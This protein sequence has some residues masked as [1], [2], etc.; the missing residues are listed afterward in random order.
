[1]RHSVSLLLL[2]AAL[3]LATGSLNAAVNKTS[4]VVE[5]RAKER[6]AAKAA[7][8]QEAAAEKKA[9]AAQPP[10]EKKPKPTATI[11]VTFSLGRP[12]YVT[13]VIE[14]AEGER[15]WNLIGDT[16][17]TAGRHTLLWDGYN[18]GDPLVHEGSRWSLTDMRRHR[19]APG[20]YRLRGLVHDGVEIKYDM[21]VQSPGT[22]PWHT[23][24]GSGAWLSDHSMPAD[25]AYLPRGSSHG[26][27]PQLFVSATLAE[28]GHAF[29]WLNQDG[30]KLYGKRCF[31][32]MGSECVAG[33]VG[34][35]PSSSIHSYSVSHRK[36]ALQ[37]MG[38]TIGGEHLTLRNIPLSEFGVASQK[39]KKPAPG[40]K[41][42]PKY[43]AKL[44]APPKPDA[45]KGLAVYNEIAVASLPSVDLLVF[46]DARPGTSRD[47]K[48]VFARVTVD[49]PK[50]LLVDADGAL[51][52]VSGTQIKRFDV[53]WL[54]GQLS[55][56]STIVASGLEMPQMIT[57]DANGHLYVTDWGKSHQVK[58]FDAKGKLVRAIGK[59]GGQQIGIYDETRMCKPLGLAVD[60]EGKLWVAE[61]NYAPK[62]ISV[63]TT[64]G[65]FVRA[66][67][68]SP[69]YGGGGILDPRDSTRYYYTG[70]SV[71]AQL[72]IEFALDWKT[73][74]SKPS[75][76]FCMTGA[77]PG[78]PVSL[79]GRAPEQAIYIDDRQYMVNSFSAAS[80]G[81]R[82]NVCVYRMGD[83]KI[84]RPVA[85][86]GFANQNRNPEKNW[87][88]LLERDDL[89]KLV[90]GGSKDKH[91]QVLFSWSDLNSDGQAQSGELRFRTLEASNA[92][93]SYA[94]H[95]L[96][97]INSGG[98]TIDPP[99]F[100]KNGVPIYDIDTMK[101][102]VEEP[103]RRH[104]AVAAKDGWHV[105]VGA[106]IEGY[107]N[108]KRVWS[109]T[110]QFPVRG[111][112][113]LP[114]TRGE[115][116]ATARLLGMSMTPPKSE[117]GEI[118]S[119]NGDKG[120]IYLMT[121][122]GLFI[123]DLGGD[124]RVIP[125]LRT[126]EFYRGMRLGDI[127]FK[128]EHFWPSTAQTADGR[129]Y[130]S[131]G[132]EFSALFEV[133]GLET[134]QRREFG[135]LTVTQ[136]MLKG[137]PQTTVAKASERH[138]KTLSVPIAAKAPMIDGRLDDWPEDGWVEIDPY[139]DI[140]G[141]MR[142]TGDTLYTAYRVGDPL[143]LVNGG[144]DGWQTIF[145]TGGGLD[146]FIRANPD[147][148]EIKTKTTVRKDASHS[149]PTPGDVRLFVTRE[150][151]PRNGRVRAVK[152]M[153]AQGDGE[154]VVYESPVKT[155]SLGSV[156]DVS[157]EVTL[158]QNG[159]DYEL[160]IPLSLLGLDAKPGLETIGDLGVLIGAGG[161][162][163]ARMYWNGGGTF[164]VS[165]VPTEAQFPTG[166][167]G[168]LIFEEE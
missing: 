127:S 136:A 162:T 149:R 53:D 65:K 153:K 39:P 93:A 14:N 98:F 129:V 40:D 28:T 17:F 56:E 120:S 161:E 54:K 2:V 165:D 132:K 45:W 107:K 166:H 101:S 7:A 106:P 130:L 128:G 111:G 12:G 75:S 160:A 73:G 92:G 167:W 72:G 68:G 15:V 27:T 74:D 13:L 52:V 10:T 42:L 71:K 168:T 86:V 66:L 150:G 1:M 146:L 84:I 11:P 105:F 109:Y 118:W 152:F 159:G 58:V 117:A 79:P 163:Q 138:H 33:D 5:A 81:G 60:G 38:H 143:R 124:E 157:D 26:D 76:I 8:K 147:A 99:V 70:A 3:L 18:V 121:T 112:G 151:D 19:V 67:Y 43:A 104:R 139:R 91:K 116:N 100:N 142:V 34:S 44:A 133:V 61:R 35:K 64:D 145:A 62:R 4:E 114:S 23:D 126:R 123:A 164:M 46:F 110:N 22:P 82:S 78:D 135:K 90:P 102:V 156:R 59:P 122:D 148:K 140:S 77:M 24:D 87:Q 21:S 41:P 113:P 95:D 30:K 83:D 134:I 6:A 32:M 51:F 36:G 69:K 119:V 125:L 55:N 31:G 115:V 37:L 80:L 9:R 89:A 108:G 94:S 63:W 25:I 88:E 57:S 29:M 48:R 155:V 96:G 50:G 103:G 49:N 16:H 137:K 144:S 141:A 97:I 154:K 131:A 158:A 20:A 85:I 47:A